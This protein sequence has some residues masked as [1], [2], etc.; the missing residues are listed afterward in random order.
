MVRGTV[1]SRIAVCTSL[2]ATALLGG[3]LSALGSAGCS[4]GEPTARVVQA[5]PE[6]VQEIEA[7]QANREEGLRSETGWLSLV[8]LFWLEPGDNRFGADP[9][10][11]VVLPEGAA[12]PLAGTF[13]LE[14]GVVRV[15]AEPGS[16]VLLDGEEVGERELSPDTSG[17]P[18]LLRLGDLHLYLIERGGKMGIRVKDPNSKPRREF[19]GLEYFP[20]NGTYRLEL[21]LDRYEEPRELPIPSSSGPAQTMVAPGD[22]TFRLDDVEHTLMPVLEGDQLFFIFG[23]QTNDEETYGGGRFLYADLEEDGTLIL[24]FN[25]AYSPPCVFTPYATCPLPPEQNRL[26]ARIEAGEKDYVGY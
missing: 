14:D 8:G 11:E 6:H 1:A 22:V 23:D 9:E 16:G 20:V 19:H 3:L 25:K 12:P 7:W 18:D 24:D 5:S 4:V 10:L 17:E 15:R 26:A 2:G 13:I 21:Q